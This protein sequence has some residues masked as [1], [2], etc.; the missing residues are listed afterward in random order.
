MQR[1]QPVQRF[2]VT[3]AVLRPKPSARSV[4]RVNA[5]AG[6]AATQ[7]PQP[8]QFTVIWRGD[9]LCFTLPSKI[10][11]AFD[12]F[13]DGVDLSL[14]VVVAIFQLNNFIPETGLSFLEDGHL[15]FGIFDHFL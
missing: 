9:V 8:V 10:K 7:R 5:W 1:P 2:A 3:V 13:F 12:K 15:R 14:Q 11:V 4:T 6:Q